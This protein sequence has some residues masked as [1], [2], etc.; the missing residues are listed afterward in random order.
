[1]R[2]CECAVKFSPVGKITGLRTIKIFRWGGGG[3]GRD[4]GWVGSVKESLPK[5]LKRGWRWVMA[6]IVRGG[7]LDLEGLSTPAPHE[8]FNCARECCNEVEVVISYGVQ[9]ETKSTNSILIL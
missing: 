4:G 7:D 9:F 2:H 6:E 8:N 5:Q 3:G 1:M